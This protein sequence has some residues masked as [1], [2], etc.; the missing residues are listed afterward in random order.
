MA[1]RKKYIKSVAERLLLD[2][3]V[4][5]VPVPVRE[6]ILSLGIQLREDR[7]EDALSG[8]LVRNAHEGLTV[9]G[10]NANHP[11]PRQRFTM[12]HE[13]G[14]YLLHE[15]EAVHF[16]K[17]RPGYSVL[18][19]STETESMNPE[20]ER[21]ANL[22][23][24]EL[25]MPETFVLEAVRQFGSMDLLEDDEA[26]RILAGQFKVSRQA[27]SIRLEALGLVSL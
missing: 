1:I 16:D 25:L 13:L 9:I 11:E 22:F 10:V 7:V 2:H 5:A 19:R 8:F 23:A 20:I 4:S 14:H 3:R 17:Q 6:I 27:L 12:A 18:L 24:A 26:F 15:N 21:E